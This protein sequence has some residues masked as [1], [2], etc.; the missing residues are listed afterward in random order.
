MVRHVERK[1]ISPDTKKSPAQPHYY[2]YTYSQLSVP[3]VESGESPLDSRESIFRLPGNH[4]N[5]SSDPLR[6]SGAH[7]KLGV[8]QFGYARLE[9]IRVLP[10][11]EV[12]VF[13]A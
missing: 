12:T 1:A 13:S 9:Q 3:C 2:D 10:A 5:I 6:E 4:I 7:Y 8:H 11:R